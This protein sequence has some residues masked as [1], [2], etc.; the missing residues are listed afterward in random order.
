M[1]CTLLIFQDYF[2]LQKSALGFKRFNLISQDMAKGVQTIHIYMYSS[3]F[4][5]NI[6]VKV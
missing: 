6:V 2:S 3:T 5:S 4:L 1:Q